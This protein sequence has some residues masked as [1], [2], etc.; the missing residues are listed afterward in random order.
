M[1]S[2]QF[3]KDVF[4]FSF[5]L[6]FYIYKNF[7]IGK[8]VRMFFFKCRIPMHSCPVKLGRTRE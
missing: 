3:P 5:I 4:F 1:I 2:I 6:Q 7:T 8:F